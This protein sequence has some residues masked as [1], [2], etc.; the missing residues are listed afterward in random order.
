MPLND[1][2]ILP[3]LTLIAP[4]VAATLAAIVFVVSRTSERAWDVYWRTRPRPLGDRPSGAAPVPNPCFPQ[5]IGEAPNP[6]ARR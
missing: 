1:A 3:D 5:A 6:E 2:P 4:T